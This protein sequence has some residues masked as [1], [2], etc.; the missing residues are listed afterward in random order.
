MYHKDKM[1]TD[2]ALLRVLLHIARAGSLRKAERTLGATQP[3]IG[4]KIA[5]LER[6]MGAQLFVR[7]TVGMTLTP[8]GQQLV[9]VA[10]EMERLAQ[11]SFTKLDPSSV[12]SSGRVRLA[13]SDGM[14]G[15]WLPPRLHDFHR[16]HP[17]ITLDIHCIGPEV[18]INLSK[19]DADITI[20]YKPPTDPDVVVLEEATLEI[21]PICTSGFLEEW[22]TPQTLDDVLSVPVIAHELHFVQRGSLKPWGDMLERHARILYRTSSSLVLAEMTRT[23]LGLTLQPVGAL[24]REPNLVML[25][26]DGYRA[27]LP[28]YLV[29]HRHVKDVPTVRAVIN[30]LKSTLF[31]EDI[32][33]SP[34]RQSRPLGAEPA[35]ARAMVG[36]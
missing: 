35:T 36:S 24:D 31:K 6:V 19:R 3:T 32:L 33:G 25:D 18:E 11:Q 5:R 28:F 21:A 8:A 26:L 17:W 10:E 12:L 15:Y 27:Y 23:G 34:A 29:C 2:W 20:L 4:K 30:H 1:V 14:A 13:M 9:R 16:I 22:G 7:T